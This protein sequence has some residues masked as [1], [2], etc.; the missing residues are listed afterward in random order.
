MNFSLPE[1]MLSSIIHVFICSSEMPVRTT[2]NFPEICTFDSLI[3]NAYWAQSGLLL[4]TLNI[5]NW[6]SDLIFSNNFLFSLFFCSLL[7]ILWLWGWASG[8]NF[9]GTFRKLAHVTTWQRCLF[10]QRSCPEVTALCNTV[11]KSNAASLCTWQAPFFL[12]TR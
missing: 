12:K 2:L 9:L 8:S 6:K 3:I 11:V 7:T 4:V 1:S 10:A 5:F